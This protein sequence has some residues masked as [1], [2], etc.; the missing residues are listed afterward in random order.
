MKQAERATSQAIALLRAE[1]DM[2][3]LLLGPAVKL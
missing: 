2:Y 1:V 3:R